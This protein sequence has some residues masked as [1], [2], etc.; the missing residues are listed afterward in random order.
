MFGNLGLVK[1]LTTRMQ[2]RCSN[3]ISQND[4]ERLHN[5][6]SLFYLVWLLSIQSQSVMLPQF[7]YLFFKAQHENHKIHWSFASQSISTRFNRPPVRFVYSMINTGM[8]LCVLPQ[9]AD[10]LNAGAGSLW[11]PLAWSWLERNSFCETSKPIWLLKYQ[12]I[13]RCSFSYFC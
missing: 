7:W 4:S 8:G 1:L 6:S 2:W 5:C 9:E 3:M 13:Y 12:P 11:V 10:R